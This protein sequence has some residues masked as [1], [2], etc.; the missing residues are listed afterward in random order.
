MIRSM[1]C[2]RAVS[3][4]IGV[5]AA[6]RTW[7]HTSRP[8]IS[9]SITS[10]TM[11]SKPSRACSFRPAPP[12]AACE[13]VKSCAA[14]IVAQHLGKPHVVLDEEDLL[15]HG[16]KLGTP[17]SRDL[18]RTAKMR[19]RPAGQQTWLAD[20]RREFGAFWAM[21]SSVKFCKSRR[22]TPRVSRIR[23]ARLIAQRLHITLPARQ[24]SEIPAV[25]SCRAASIENGRVVSCPK[26]ILRTRSGHPRASRS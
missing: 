19:R 1:A 14:E 6:P 18:I 3:I 9:G 7:R 11:A 26:M 12:L 13:T 8:S 23:R 10:S 2:P 5:A 16:L 21:L 17:N 4:R 15:H 24:T 22:I 20:A 25:S